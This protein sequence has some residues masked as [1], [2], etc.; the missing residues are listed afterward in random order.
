MKCEKMYRTKRKSNK[1][2]KIIIVIILLA[3]IAAFCLYYSPYVFDKYGIKQP[4]KAISFEIN[5]DNINDVPYCLSKEGIIK[6]VNLFKKYMSDTYGTNYTYTKGIYKINANM[7][8]KQ[9][10]E[11]FQ[12]PDSV[13]AT[14]VIPEGK[15]CYEIS[16]IL[17]QNGICSSKDFIK[18]LNDKYDY[19]FL[20][21][22]KNPEQRPYKLEG[23]LYP[24]SYEIV[25]GSSA[26]DVID[27]MLNAM[28][29][30]LEDGILEECESKGVSIDD[31]LT[32]ASIV[33]KEA[34]GYPADMGKVAGVFWNRLNNPTAQN[35][36]TLGSDPTVHYADLLEK[37]GY[38]ES[39]WKAYSTYSTQG[40]PTGP[41]C[42]PSD[43]AIKA[44][45]EPETS[46][47]YYFFTDK[48]GV[49]HYFK[50][51]EEFQKGWKS[52]S[53]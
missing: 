4:N 48:N 47:Y 5:D 29:L 26:H 37:Q 23:Y 1:T 35:T 30:R 9:L 12:K 31:V 7:S 44:A 8:Y 27:M 24:A 46:E 53:K 51:Y 20:S 3:A 34:S 41:I 50:T 19:E 2:K 33:E 15:N 13:A 21:E 43:I 6:S 28:Q 45:L 25:E 16:K 32:M 22:I 36:P 39:I 49:F 42:S 18:A 52:A 11:K 10:G 40:L 38:E 17:E 14:V